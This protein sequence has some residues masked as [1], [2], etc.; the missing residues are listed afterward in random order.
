MRPIMLPATL[1]AIAAAQARYGFLDAAQVK[2]LAA[3]NATRLE[4]LLV[5]CGA[6]R[7]LAPAQDVE[8]MLGYV[9]AGGDSTTTH[10]TTTGN[11]TG[12][13]RGT[14]GRQPFERLPGRR[15]C[16]PPVPKPGDPASLAA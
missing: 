16:G 8:R 4:C 2:T 11:P 15:Q 10:R 6:V 5:R 1:D 9:Q 7:F 14:A 13:R 12:K 3:D